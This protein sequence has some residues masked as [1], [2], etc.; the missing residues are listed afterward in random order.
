MKG[1]AGSEILARQE[2]VQI[3]SS[4]RTGLKADFGSNAPRNVTL[5]GSRKPRPSA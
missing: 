4:G 3:R 5:G 1:M 2:G